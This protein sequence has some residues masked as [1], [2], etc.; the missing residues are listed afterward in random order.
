M[1][2]SQR[3]P[4]LQDNHSHPYLYATL[5]D[6]LDISNVTSKLQALSLITGSLSDNDVSVVI[7]W[8]N[9]HFDFSDS[10]LER[11]PP[12]IIFNLSLHALLM[13]YSAR[14]IVA[15]RFPKLAE[16]YRDQKWLE[17]NTSLALNFLV[18]IKGCSPGKL[19]A[20][21]DF[22]ARSGVWRAAEMSL[23]NEEWL[24][25]FFEA[26]LAERAIFW[27]DSESFQR[28]SDAGQTRMHGIKLF[29][30]GALGSMSAAL[31]RPYLSGTEG[32]LIHGD[33]DLRQI[34]SKMYD[35]GKAVAV[36]AVGDMAIDQVIRVLETIGTQRCGL[37]ETRIEHCQFI[38]KQ[39]AVKA[40]ALGVIL[41]MQPN[42]SF[43]SVCYRERLPEEYCRL[44]NP[45][46]MLLDEVGYVAGR[47]LV[48]GSDGMPH[49]VGR[50]LESSLFPPFPGQRISLEE[51]IAGYCMPDM[52]HGHIDIMINDAIRKVDTQVTLI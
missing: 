4:L 34:I 50:A 49:G 1:K 51:F 9:G 6:C 22:L 52:R 38:S 10:E 35:M 44:N 11:F 31:H 29:A 18:D 47:D 7:G 17:K 5:S 3:I 32:I 43:D 36:H 20:Y 24:N 40:K 41:S 23:K 14:K 42:F 48:F 30:D 28:M 2:I 8:N 15:R 19:R 33:E 13:N 25:K 12:L 26:N 46:R 39:A 21:Y 37:P 16:R 45:F 27:C